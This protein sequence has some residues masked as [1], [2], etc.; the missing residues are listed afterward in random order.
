[1]KYA[2]LSDIHGNCYALSAVL[3]AISKEKI[4]TLII[5]GDFIGYYFWPKEVFELLKSW[6]IVAI[7]GNHDK[8]LMKAKEDDLFLKEATKKYGDG[9]KIALDQ[10]DDQVSSWLLSLPDSR[11]FDLDQNKK[12][13]LCHGSPWG[14]DEYIYPDSDGESL[15]RY[16]NLNVDYVQQGHTHYSMIKNIENVTVINPGSVGQPRDRNL[17]ANWAILDT[18]LDKVELICEAY[19]SRKVIKE[20]QKINPDIPYLA[21]I[22]SRK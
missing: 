22:L 2:L 19:D 18:N 11:V 1:M 13:F 6:D 15:K 14:C 4:H 5:T 16:A 8:M 7:R 3:D 20:S 21:E 12:I 10:L 9:L 17:G